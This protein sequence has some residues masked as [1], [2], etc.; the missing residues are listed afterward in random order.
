M[1]FG[2]LL[3]AAAP[4]QAQESETLTVQTFVVEHLGLTRAQDLDFGN[5]IPDTGGTVVMTPNPQLIPGP[6][7]TAT[8]VETGTVIHTN[9]CIP[10]VFAGSGT[11][12]QR[13]RIRVPQQGEILLANAAGDEMLIS[14]ITLSG[15]P[16]LNLQKE[17]VR[18]WR[19]R[20]A[21]PNGLFYFRL[22]GTLNV[23]N[24]QP[25]GTYTAE[26]DVDVQYF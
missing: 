12:N 7:G 11:F 24:A 15:H 5:I 22:G 17:N 19:F 25:A 8:C 21:D 6:T 20:I 13:V 14:N 9:E 18:T 4:A 16:T 26:F 23:D 3:L 2:T 1:I 10:A